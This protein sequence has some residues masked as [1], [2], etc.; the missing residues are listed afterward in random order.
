MANA[1]KTVIFTFNEEKFKPS[2]RLNQLSG[3]LKDL[4]PVA[5][6]ENNE[7]EVPIKHEVT[8][9]DLELLNKFIEV[10]HEKYGNDLVTHADDLSHWMSNIVS[11]FRV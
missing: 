2:P 8:K 3:M 10:C 6:S 1:E 5:S 7:L 11:Y 4:L 9:E